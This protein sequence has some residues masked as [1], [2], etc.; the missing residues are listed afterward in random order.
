MSVVTVAMSDAGIPTLYR[1]DATLSFDEL[2]GRLF[3]SMPRSDQRRTGMEYLRG[4]VHTS[5]HTSTRGLAAQP[6]VRANSQSLHHF[7]AKSSWDWRPVR[8]ALADQLV[9]A[10]LPGA[11]VVQQFPATRPPGHPSG[12]VP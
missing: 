3:A 2:C 8:R 5:G 12:V 7:I 6:S 9:Q 11:W 1:A 10:L 4:L